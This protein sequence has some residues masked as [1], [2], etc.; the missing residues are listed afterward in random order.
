MKRGL[1]ITL[2]YVVEQVTNKNREKGL[3][4]VICNI[5]RMRNIV[6]AS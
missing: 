4:I 1:Q 6:A 3:N 5:Q 2:R